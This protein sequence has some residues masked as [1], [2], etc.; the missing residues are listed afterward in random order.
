MIVVSNN[1]VPEYPK[2]ETLYNRD[3]NNMKRIVVGDF[4]C[5]EFKAIN[6]WRISEKVDGTNTR[7][8]TLPGGQVFYGC[9]TDSAQLPPFLLQF[10]VDT[11]PLEI[12]RK[13]IQE[14]T[15]VITIYGEGYGHKIQK[16]VN[17]RESG[18]SFRVFDIRVGDIW[19]SYEAVE[20]IAANIGMP[21]VPNFGVMD[22]D[23]AVAG[24]GGFSVVSQQEGGNKEYVA[25][26]IVAKSEPLML[27][28]IGE[29]IIWKL[30][31][32]DFDEILY[33]LISE[34]NK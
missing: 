10:L 27:N 14:S 29:R 2:I 24:I 23:S 28:R 13:G 32:R 30:K 31:V 1:M 17:Y 21:T 26:G 12:L 19:L 7:I 6:R 8:A 16:G 22:F 11:Y 20:E 34:R 18:V 4:R 9:R 33:Y 15:E 5:P 3:P 25:E